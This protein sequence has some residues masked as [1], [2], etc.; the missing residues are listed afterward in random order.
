MDMARTIKYVLFGVLY[1]IIWAI[2]W[3]FVIINLYRYEVIIF[4]QSPIIYG[5]YCNIILLITRIKF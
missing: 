3:V 1:L 4:L 2:D 5:I